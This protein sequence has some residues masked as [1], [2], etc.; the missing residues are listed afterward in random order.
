[1]G[2]IACSKAIKTDITLPYFCI[3]YCNVPVYH[4]QTDNAS[5]IVGLYNHVSTV[6]IVPVKN[7]IMNVSYTQLG[8]FPIY[9]RSVL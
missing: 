9:T 1:M 3:I 2:E 4:C 6:T 8:H 5:F 7:N